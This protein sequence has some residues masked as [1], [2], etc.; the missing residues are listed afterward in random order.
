MGKLSTVRLHVSHEHIVDI[1]LKMVAI[2]ADD[3]LGESDGRIAS[4]PV[5]CRLKHDFF[6]GIT[7]RLVEPCG[8]FWFPEYICH[9]VVTNTVTGAEISVR[10]VIEGAPSN[11]AR[12]L[13]IGGELIM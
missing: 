7:L 2:G 13:Q 3:R 10:V 8:R 1:E 6:C 11:P 5:E 9:P 4:G 12:I